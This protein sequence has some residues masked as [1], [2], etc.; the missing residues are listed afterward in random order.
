L[1]NAA[2][3]ALA[4][5]LLCAVSELGMPQ[6]KP[7]PPFDAVATEAKASQG[8]VAAMVQLGNAYWGGHG[9]TADMEKG[10]VWLDRAA[11]KGSLDAQMLL[12][13]AYLSGTKLSKD[14]QLASK[15]LLEA[16]QQQHVDTG[17]QSSRAL[18]Q[19]WIALMYEH[20]NGLEKSHDKAI[21]FL[22]MAANNGSSPA[23][24]DLAALYN[25]GT[26]G[27]AMDK[28]HACEL[29]E[30]AA[31]QGHVRAMHNAGYCYQVGIGGKKDN[32]KA[33]GY[34]TKA[35]EAGSTRAQHNL[36]IL[37]GQLGQAEKSYFWLRVAESSGESET[38]S[39]IETA[40][41]HLTSSEVQSA[42]SDVAVWLN[43]HKAK[44]Q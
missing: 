15:Y 28:V 5:V 25:E 8:D 42:D 22:Q 2:K 7:T 10:R 6:E 13:A 12:G 26:G 38:K 11:A 1:V 21:E 18:A 36:G 14:P 9:V 16:A 34:Y 27:I 20:G 4:I 19:Y 39:Q 43:A 37:F 30:K 3:F 23:Q 24:Y 31:D 35:A 33:I 29:F 32:S 17:L 44:K 40:K 41:E